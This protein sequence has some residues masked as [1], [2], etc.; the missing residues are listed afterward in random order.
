MSRPEFLTSAGAVIIE[1]E[2]MEPY[3]REIDGAPDSVQGL[4]LDLLERLLNEA[5]ATTTAVTS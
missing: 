3:V 4:P 2:L 5:A 1:H